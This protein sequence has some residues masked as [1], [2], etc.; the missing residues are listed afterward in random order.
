[1]RD[2]RTLPWLE[3]IWR[4]GGP[5][6]IGGPFSL[7]DGQPI[8]GGSPHDGRTP[9]LSTEQLL[10]GSY[11]SE[12]LVLAAEL[13]RADGWSEERIRRDVYAPFIVAGPASWGD[14]WHA[15]RHGPGSIVRQHEGQDVLCRYGAEVLAPE[16]G[17]IEFDT[18][19]LG[20]RTA[21]LYRSDGGYYYFAHLV[22][23]NDRRFSDGDEVQRGDVIGYCGDTGNAT[24]PHVHVG[25]YGPEGEAIDPM[26]RL[27]SWLH[28][29]EGDLPR[30][31]SKAAAD[32]AEALG[33]A[34]PLDTAWALLH[35]P[36]SEDALNAWRNAPSRESHGP[37]DLT[38]LLMLLVLVGVT[39]RR[40]V[41]GPNRGWIQLPGVR[42]LTA[43]VRA[44]RRVPLLS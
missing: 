30:S 36:L 42:V 6:L 22:D 21:R 1:V 27:V 24:V 32:A 44:E 28:E 29:A 26:R 43:T 23:R 13:L 16:D 20:G 40:S 18:S 5:V 3:L 7:G 34:P 35:D 31:V 17:T 14:S 4:A 25:W 2:V 15:P 39:A 37:L 8:E 41:H 33:S 10:S 38:P 19:L 12:T 9:D 11:S